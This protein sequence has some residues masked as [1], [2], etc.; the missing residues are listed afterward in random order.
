MKR[1]L[2]ELLY[3]REDARS[4]EKIFLRSIAASIC[5]IL[6]CLAC[7][8]ST[9]WAWFV[10]NISTDTTTIQAAALG[11]TVKAGENTIDPTE[12]GGGT[13]QLSAG[14]YTVT[15][16]PKESTAVGYCLIDVIEDNA[17]ATMRQVD[18]Q[19]SAAAEEILAQLQTASGEELNAIEALTTASGQYVAEGTYYATWGSGNTFG[20]KIE[21][22]GTVTLALI[23]Q[24]GVPS[25]NI[26]AID[27]ANL[28][29]ME[30]QAE[31]GMIR[32][33]QASYDA[34]ADIQAAWDRINAQIPE[35]LAPPAVEET[36]P[37]EMPAPEQ[38]LPPA[39]QQPEESQPVTEEEPAVEEEPAA[40]PESEPAEQPA[41]QE[42]PAVTPEETAPVETEAAE[43]SSEEEPPAEEE[44]PAE[45]DT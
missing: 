25:N 39:I 23:P 30:G 35:E 43:V 21:G 19:V 27:A 18:A 29:S 22:S 45:S 44:T 4:S 1:L 36:P 24:W 5:S 41:E 42:E 17:Q 16:V 6:L 31:E 12:P 3:S 32:T 2:N 34:S 8:A 13:Y 14:D 26:P 10:M 40:L 20:L 7:L 37:E 38:V 28:L 11:V 33:Y 15:L 9:T